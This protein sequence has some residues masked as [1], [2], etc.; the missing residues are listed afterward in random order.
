[1]GALGEAVRLPEIGRTRYIVTQQ[2]SGTIAVDS[3]VGEF[4]EFTIRLKTMSN[5]RRCVQ[6]RSA[7]R[8][9]ASQ[10]QIFLANPDLRPALGCLA[11][12]AVALLLIR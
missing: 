11:A 8:L 9:L 1:V 2:H 12:I 7:A 10:F 6:G 5:A 3:R 4:S